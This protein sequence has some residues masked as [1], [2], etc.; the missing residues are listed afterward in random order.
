MNLIF[1]FHLIRY[2]LPTKQYPCDCS[3]WLLF[4]FFF[5]SNNLILMANSKCAQQFIICTNV[6]TY[7]RINIGH[8][9]ITYYAIC[10]NIL[11]FPL[12]RLNV[13]AGEL[14]EYNLCMQNSDYEERE[15][16]CDINRFVYIVRARSRM[17]TIYIW[18]SNF[19]YC[20]IVVSCCWL[21][22][23][24]NKQTIEWTTAFCCHL[25]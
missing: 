10:V 23:K 6:H 3:V 14:C 13:I 12:I 18:I 15:F 1:P 25:N 16:G 8:L 22:E 24:T 11:A 7:L 17:D 19:P 4:F 20:R 21:D 5:Q 9:N 2:A